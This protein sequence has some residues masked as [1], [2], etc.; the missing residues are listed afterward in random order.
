MKSVGEVMA[1]GR[2]FEEAIQKAVRMLEIGKVGLVG[3]PDED[4]DET[5]DQLRKALYEPTD[6]RLFKLV[7]ALKKGMSIDEVFQLTGFDKF[8]LHKIMHIIEIEKKLKA[9][10]R[11]SDENEVAKLI[12][13][14]KTYGFSDKQ[15]GKCLKT[16]DLS[17]RRIRQRNSINPV[18][19]QID[20]TA[21]EWPA[22]INYLYATYCGNKD[23]VDFSNKNGKKIIVLGSGT[24]R[25]G[26]SVEFD[27]GSVNLVWALKKLGINQVIMY[28]YNPETVSTDYDISDKLYFE[29][30]TF[31]RVLDIYEK[32]NPFGI[33][34]SVG[35]QTPNNLAPKL[36]T[37]S[38]I[39]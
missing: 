25:I 1:I 9:F 33:V 24:Y 19:K 34:V 6:E 39:V 4:V 2:N 20:T 12:K 26:S 7:K 13:T 3:N 5:L 27:W 22:Q 30:M 36:A 23:D 10:N 8:F 31:E 37:A 35:G 38:G 14:A 11:L 17:I 15:I 21:A 28:N 29:E 18:I 32:E 16:N